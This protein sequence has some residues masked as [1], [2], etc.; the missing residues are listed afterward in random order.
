MKLN[1][2]FVEKVREE[3]A[4]LTETGLHPK[5]PRTQAIVRMWATACP[6]LTQALKESGI[7]DAMANVVNDQVLTLARKTPGEYAEARQRAEREL[8]PFDRETEAEFLS[9]HTAA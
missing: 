4:R 7:L 1:P 3:N 2:T 6:R 9:L 8:I 5:L